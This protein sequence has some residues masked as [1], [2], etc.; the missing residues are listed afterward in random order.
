[1]SDYAKPLPRGEDVNG[2]FYQ[3]CKQHELCFQRCQ[4]CSTWRHMPRE[5]CAT[6][7]SSR[8]QRC[9]GSDW[10]LDRVGKWWRIPIAW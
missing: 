4:D 7:G 9:R 1:M 6:C 8:S 3:F 2:E 10:A 5:S